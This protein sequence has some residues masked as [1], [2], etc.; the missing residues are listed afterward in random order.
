MAF[1]E[2]DEV[3]VTTHGVNHVGVI[4]DR[5]VVSKT[6]V[7]DVLLENR[8]ALT[9]IGTA[10]SAKTFIN[11]ALTDKLIDTEIIKSTIPYKELLANE[12][13]PICHPNS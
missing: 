4:L 2:G 12:E 9:F 11:R 7:Y 6:N 5:R 13:L 10:Q 8:S 1:K 3:I